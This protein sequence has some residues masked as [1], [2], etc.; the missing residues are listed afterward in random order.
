MNIVTFSTALS[1]APPKL[2]AVSLYH[3]TLTKDAFL[4]SGRG[5]LQLLRPKQ[6]ALVPIL[7]KN[8]GYTLDKRQACAALGW[9]WVTVSKQ[10]A[11]VS[12]EVTVLPDCAV[13]LD[14]R[15]E[16]TLLAG[17]HTLAICRVVGTR[18][19]RQDEVAPEKQMVDGE[20]QPGALGANDVLY[21]GLL[22]EEGII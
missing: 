19:W 13:Y 4:T 6:K 1:V 15:V 5:I 17:D 16:S 20:M 18:Q 7:G 8:S 22:R 2:H 9:D 3:D 14:L 12:D 21:T 11:G 10:G